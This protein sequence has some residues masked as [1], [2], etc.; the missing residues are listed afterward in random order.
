MQ[1]Q[2]NTTDRILVIDSTPTVHLNGNT[3]SSLEDEW[4]TFRRALQVAIEAVPVESF[5]GRNHYVKP[6]GLGDSTRA[7]QE[8]Q[9]RLLGLLDVADDV[10]EGIADQAGR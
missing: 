2:K 8:I 6:D 4:A 5:H 10:R 1:T 9:T 7:R 3:A